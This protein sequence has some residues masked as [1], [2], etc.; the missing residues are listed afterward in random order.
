MF[1]CTIIVRN[2]KIYNACTMKKNKKE[3]RIKTESEQSGERSESW[4]RRN[5]SNIVIMLAFFVGLGLLLYPSVSDYWNSFHQS[6]AIMS[7]TS[8]VSKLDTSEYER[9]IA[10][11]QEYNRNISDNGIDWILTDEDKARY[12][13]ELNFAVGG[14]MGYI[15]IDKIN[16]K[17]S[18]YHGTSEAVLQTSV[19][20][21]EGT[22]L[23][24]GTASFDHKTGEVTDQTEGVH[25]ALSGHRG[26]PRAKLFSD[27]DRLTEGDRF[28]IVVLNETYTYEVDQIRIV[29]PSDLSDLVI[30]PGKDYC[31]LITCTPYGIN[32]HRLLVRGHRVENAGGDLLVTADAVQYEPYYI[33][34]FVAIPIIILLIIILFLISA[35]PKVNIEDIKK[36]LNL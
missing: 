34:P 32:T 20:H 33:A 1:F 21:L 11:A 22:S 10:S 27:L 23:P 14:N 18:I 3:S 25:I 26:L 9:I 4:F 31:T 30:E 36:K 19:G 15:Q 2:V 7:Y 13:N 29:E 16:V 28:A 12:E 8:D 6:R 35:Q 24:V 5:W 17:L